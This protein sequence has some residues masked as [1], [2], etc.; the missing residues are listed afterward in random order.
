MKPVI[1]KQCNVMYAVNQEEY[2]NLPA[3]KTDD[4]IITSIWELTL[5]EKIKLLFG[6]K[7]IMG[8]HTFNQPLQPIILQIMKI[9]KVKDKQNGKR[10]D[11]KSGS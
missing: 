11:Y 10:I 2:Q 4:G 5:L 6:A 3:Y 9:R 7:L 8:C 1:F